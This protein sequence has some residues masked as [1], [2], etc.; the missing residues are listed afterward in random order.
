MVIISPGFIS[1]IVSAST[2]SKAQVSDAITYELFIA[3]KTNGLKPL[4]SLAA[5][6]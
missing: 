2:K 1:R 4:G 5:I 3:P 6:I